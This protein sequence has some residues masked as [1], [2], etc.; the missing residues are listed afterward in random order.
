MFLRPCYLLGL[1]FDLCERECPF[2]S[3]EFRIGA[4]EAGQPNPRRRRANRP[5]IITERKRNDFKPERLLFAI[6]PKAGFVMVEF[7]LNEATSLVAYLDLFAE[8]MKDEKSPVYKA[9]EKRL[10]SAEL[11]RTAT[12]LEK[13]RKAVREA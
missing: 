1:G 12:C 7:T 2:R 11:M 3:Y 4:R 13:V 8:A 5:C 10:K 9:F 6:M